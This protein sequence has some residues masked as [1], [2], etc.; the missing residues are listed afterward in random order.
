VKSV[1]MP[2]LPVVGGANMRPV[3]LSLAIISALFPVNSDAA[4]AA[5][6]V[7][8]LHATIPDDTPLDAVQWTGGFWQDRMRRLRDIY[9]PGVLDGS[10]TTVENG[11]TFRNLLRAAQ[12]EQGGALGH[13]WSDGDC[14]LVLDTAARLYAYRPD[15]YLERKLDY[16]VPIIGRIQRSDGLVDTWTVLKSFDSK[17]GKEWERIN[18]PK[19]SGKPFQ[20][21]LVYNLGSLHAAATTHQR[22]TGDDR[23]LAI[24]DKAVLCWVSGGDRIANDPMQWAMSPLYSR[25]GDTRYLDALRRAY[26]RQ[27]TFGPPLREAPEV[28]GHNT[29]TAHYLLGSAALYGFTGGQDLRNALV[30]LAANMLAKKTYI[31][32]AVAPVFQGQ[33]PAQTI[34]GKTYPAA[35]IHEAVGNAYDLPNDSAYCE[36]CGQALYMEW[37]YRMFR[38]TGDAVYMDAAERALYNTVPGCVDLERPNFF[39]CNPQ[40][41]LPTSKRSRTNG[42]GSAWDANYTW[43]RQY[44]KK[45]ACCPPKVMRAIAMSVEMAYNVNR[46]G[47]WVNLYGENTARLILPEGGSWECQ[48]TSVFPWDGKVKLVL[49]KVESPKPFSLFLRIPGWVDG[50]VRIAVN[51][52]PV[53]HNPPS[54]AYHRIQRQWKSGDIVELDLPMPVRF[55]AA[56]PNVADA[57]GKIAVQRGPIVYCLEGD[58]ISENAE[59]EHIRV[60]AW[61]DLKPVIS[62]EL[63][64]VTK[65]TGSLVY[66]TTALVSADRLVED[67][68]ETALYRPARFADTARKLEGG[69]QQVTVSLIPYYARLNRESDY[70]RIW[71]PAY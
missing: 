54:G 28:F 60:P 39:Y 46:D 16:W 41:Q 49:H 35:A 43:R 51:G 2:E 29:V 58:D 4:T 61:A 33:R 57:R 13:T 22:A 21:L 71:L 3:I 38:L 12:M 11:A 70:F 9:L 53:A 25:T 65:L 17:D 24:A 68:A 34:E 66:S 31:T 1:T 8:A 56:H 50:A 14:Y 69:D 59:V 20:G 40:E 5:E 30:R 26:E 63:G 55:M 45:C 23:F 62:T 67:P 42:L 36:S 19:L 7:A 15:D 47:V 44:T 52:E 48:Q 6:K 64:G 32:G 10:F 18:K 37:Y 27:S